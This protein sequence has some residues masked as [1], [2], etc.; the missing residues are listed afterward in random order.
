MIEESNKGD[1]GDIGVVDTLITDVEGEK[2]IEAL[3]REF[4]LFQNFPNPFNSF[5]EIRYRLPER[6]DV[7]LAVYDLLGRRVSTLVDE[8]PA[9]GA[10]QV[11][12]DGKDTDGLDV[13]SGIYLYRLKAGED[14]V[15]TRRML[16]LR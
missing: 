9:Q 4:A 6:T 15:Q 8:S 1:D 3:S 13:A 16:L 10:Y 5:T 14:V 12:W 11:Q 7:K 2:H